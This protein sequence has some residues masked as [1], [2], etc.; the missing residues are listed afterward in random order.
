MEFWKDSFDEK[1][2]TATFTVMRKGS[3]EPTVR[4]FSQA[5]AQKAGLWTKAG[6]WT[7][8][9]KRMLFQRAR[10]FALRDTFADVLKGLRIVEEERDIIEV[11]R[12]ADGSYAMP[13]AAEEKKEEPARQCAEPAPAQPAEKSEAK[14]WPSGKEEEDDEGSTSFVPVRV[15]KDNSGRAL[16]LSPSGEAFVSDDKKMIATAE[17]AIKNK[18]NVIMFFRVAGGEQIITSLELEGA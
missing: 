14:I 8:Y 4:T 10:A 12:Q 18:N 15:A 2:M 6:P 1:T 17:T 7:Q 16:V 3:P 11:A 13:K 5:D 9:P